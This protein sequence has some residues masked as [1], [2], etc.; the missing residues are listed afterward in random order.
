[1]CIYDDFSCAEFLSGSVCVCVYMCTCVCIAFFHSVCVCVCVLFLSLRVYV[2]M[3]C[4]CG[5]GG[6]V[7]GRSGRLREEE[8]TGHTACCFFLFSFVLVP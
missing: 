6:G 7:T 1:M 4:V 5:G 2:C 3:V 8:V